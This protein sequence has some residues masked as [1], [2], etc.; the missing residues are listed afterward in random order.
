MS[1][2]LVR[3][4]VCY[5]NADIEKLKTFTTDVGQMQLVMWSSPRSHDAYTAIATMNSQMD[6]MLPSGAAVRR[7]K[8]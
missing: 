4:F 3:L 6:I 1:V 2:R 5:G 7:T 8:Y